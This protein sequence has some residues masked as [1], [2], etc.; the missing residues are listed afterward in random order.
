V[1]TLRAHSLGLVAPGLPVDDESPTETDI[2]GNLGALVVDG[3]LK[4]ASVHATGNIGR[5]Q[6]GGS[7][8]AGPYGGDLVAGGSIGTVKIGGSVVG[9]G[10]TYLPPI[11]GQIITFL[12]GRI[13][14]GG[15][16]GSVKIGGS[17][18][19]SIFRHTGTIEADGKVGSISI[20]GDLVGFD[21]ASHVGAIEVGG[22]LGKLTIGGSII[23]KAAD[24]VDVTHNGGVFV[25]GKLG[26]FRVRNFIYSGDIEGVGSL[27]YSGCVVADAIGRGRI[28]GT[29]FAGSLHGTGSFEATGSIVAHKTIG[30]LRIGEDLRGGQGSHAGIYVG[31]FSGDGN[32]VSN[33]V[34]KNL[35][36]GGD[37]VRA[38]IVAGVEPG[39]LLLANTEVQIGTV[40]VG[41]DWSLSNL[42]VG[43][44]RG[45]DG[46]F[47]TI[48]DD[49]FGHA[50][51][52]TG[53][54]SSIAK[55]TIKGQVSGSLLD[56]DDSYGFVAERIGAFSANGVK[57]KL[58]KG[59]NSL[60]DFDL[61]PGASDVRVAELSQINI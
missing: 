34:L 48:D 2:V 17:V 3:D 52:H 24:T 42:S 33:V 32:G 43:A 38:N 56:L 29:V 18:T 5:I 12:G 25:G 39:N 61:V 59:A 9:G 49:L 57:L 53:V 46:D 4:G 54:V 11:P 51:L 45:M 30:S 22:N 27:S 60:G 8:L 16:I 13:L 31:A 50:P 58:T 28:D 10:G 44:T 23:G 47:G 20:G 55:I 1:K 41:G 40:R 19:G 37:V 35:S 14:A 26:Q 7:V 15:D 21:S 6:I 36:I